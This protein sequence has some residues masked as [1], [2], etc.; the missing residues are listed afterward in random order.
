MKKIIKYTAVFLIFGFIF[1]SSQRLLTPKYMSEIYDGALIGEYYPEPKNHSVIF[2]GDCEVYQNFSPHELFR[3]YGITS[4]IRGGASQTIWQSYW[5][6]EDTLKYETPDVVVFSVLS[7]GK[8]ESVS[9]PYNRLNIEGMRLSSAKMRAIESSAFD[10]EKKINYVFPIFRYHDR[11]R[12][13]TR[14]DFKYFFRSDQVGLNGYLMRSETEPAT[15]FPEGARL[16]DYALPEICWAY[17]DKMREL[18]ESHGIELILVKSPSIWPY[19]YEQWDSQV[20]EYADRYNLLY[21]N[22]LKLCDE[23]GIDYQTDTANAGKHMNVHG[24]EKL[25]R[26][27]GGELLKRFSLTDYRGDSNTALVWERKMRD[28]NSLKATQ[29]TEFR[30]HGEISTV[31]YVKSK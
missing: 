1:F 17:L 10:G 13:L 31:T 28:Y 27:L 6:L 24:A 8:S 5:L 3:E 14:D 16:V 2:I 9:E 4:Y 12:E 20:T 21:Y 30:E 25:S 18:C 23:T 7:M 22:L 15:V 29:L 11:W 26:W 19:W